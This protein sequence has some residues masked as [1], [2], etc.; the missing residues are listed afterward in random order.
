MYRRASALMIAAL[1][2]LGA[3]A[4]VGA[5]EQP[6][7]LTWVNLVEVQPA[8]GR[9][10]VEMVERYDKAILD[11]LVEDGTFISWGLGRHV[12]G[13]PGV[14]YALWATAPSWAALGTGVAAF[15]K[16]RSEM[17][18]DEMQEMMEGFASAV[19]EGSRE[20]Q[21]IRHLVFEADEDAAPPKYLRLAAYTVDEGRW[22]DA[23]KMYETYLEPVYGSLL[24]S[25]A[26]SG[27][28]VAVPAVHGGEDFTH[29]AWIVFS[30]LGALDEVEGAFMR[31]ESEAADGEM[32]A[33]KAAFMGMMEPGTHYDRLLRIV[34]S[35]E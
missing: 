30:D 27:Y 19:K 20:I 22:D 5:Q 31:N 6:M 10:Y 34:M 12:L 8:A 14:D 2:G 13:P 29:E 7:P 23:M 28:G 33:R 25:G 11:S 9:Q 1:V 35:S 26:V 18:S 3:G 16:A 17:S 4:G 32:V 21:I 24:S 15:E